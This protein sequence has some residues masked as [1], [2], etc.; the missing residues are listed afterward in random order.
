MKKL[1]PLDAGVAVLCAICGLA[2]GIVLYRSAAS[3]VQRDLLLILGAFG[4][5]LG[6]IWLGWLAWR[7][8]SGHGLR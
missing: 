1:S 5:A 7:R 8:R 4:L 2:F 6:V 3:S